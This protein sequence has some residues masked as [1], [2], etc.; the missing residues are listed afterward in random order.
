M[1]ATLPHGAQNSVPLQKPLTYQMSVT[2]AYLLS[3]Q[4]FPPGQDLAVYMDELS[5]KKEEVRLRTVPQLLGSSKTT[6]E[7]SLADHMR[8]TGQMKIV[9][10]APPDILSFGPN[11]HAYQNRLRAAYS[12]EDGTEI[13]LWSVQERNLMPHLEAVLQI[14]WTKPWGKGLRQAQKAFLVRGDIWF[15]TFIACRAHI[16][17][18]W[19]GGKATK[20]SS[21]GGGEATTTTSGGGGSGGGAAKRKVSRSSKQSSS[22]ATTSSTATYSVQN[23]VAAIGKGR[24]ASEENDTGSDDDFET[25]TKKTKKSKRAFGVDYVFDE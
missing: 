18:A 16:E 3:A 17:S 12:D 8:K 13:G 25:K 23:T 19:G 5:L 14:G 6:V 10:P 22:S 9:P 7:E 2:Y 20:T 21:G 15:G 24:F 11:Y 4:E 1:L